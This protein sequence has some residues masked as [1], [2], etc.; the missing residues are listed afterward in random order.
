MHP[1]KSHHRS[2]VHGQ[3]STLVGKSAATSTKSFPA[4]QGLGTS[5]VHLPCFH[6][7]KHH[8]M[9]TK[10]CDDFSQ[11]RYRELL[12]RNHSVPVIISISDLWR[13]QPIPEAS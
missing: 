4:S 8:G 11:S 13:M 3:V 2:T 10:L 7:K 12:T 1:Y 9:N 5:N 6:S